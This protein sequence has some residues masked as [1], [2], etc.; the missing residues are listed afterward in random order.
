MSYL[1]MFFLTLLAAVALAACVPAGG[2]ADVPQPLPSPAGEWTLKLVQSGG[3]AGVN[4]TVEIDSHG[5][6]TAADKRTGR[7]ATQ[8]LSPDTMNK[9]AR[10]YSQAALITPKTPR[11]GCADCFNYS[12]EL[13]S[14]GRPMQIQLDDTT[15]SDSGMADLIHLL[16]QLRDQ[17]LKAAP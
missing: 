8:S 9:L 11:S 3:F 4:Q 6:L 5:R 1:R 2:A 16:Q 12:L 10:L 17:A 7:T 15:L 14:G 13:S